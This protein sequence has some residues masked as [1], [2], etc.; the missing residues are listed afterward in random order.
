MAD[1]NKINTEEKITKEQFSKKTKIIAGILLVCILA[2]VAAAVWNAI[3]P[4]KLAST[5]ENK[6]AAGNNGG[7]FPLAISGSKVANENL[8][9]WDGNVAYVSDTS[10][11]ALNSTAATSVN[12][13]ISYASPVIKTD[14][15]YSIIYNL[16]GA[17]LEIDT[18]KETVFKSTNKDVII[19]ADINA[20]GMYAVLTQTSGYL[21]KLTVYNADNTQKYAYYFSEYYAH[22]VS[23]NQDGSY[24]AVSAVSSNDGTMKSVMYI[25]N[26]SKEEPQAIIDLGDNL[27]LDSDY[28][29]NGNIIAVGDKKT[30]VISNNEEAQL[31]S[32][33]GLTLTAF[34]IDSQNGAAVSLSRSGDGRACNLVY[35][36]KNG[37][38]GEPAQ[39]DL[40]ISSVSMYGG[41]IAALSGSEVNLFDKSNNLLRT[42]DGGVDAKAICMASESSAYVLGVSEI[43]F[44]HLQ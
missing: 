33:D 7:G 41:K 30:S 23:L 17:G 2:V 34:A 12:R 28:M 14:G 29:N 11:I 27:V 3:A 40:K 21:A 36:H 38:I 42:V 22:T 18:L 4:D 1:E 26:L 25:L 5:V 44:I 20:N 43:R 32:Y 8:R 24:A 39:T 35:I 37:N 16:G 31:Y 19:S 10:L 9:L 6:I 13:Q 15:A